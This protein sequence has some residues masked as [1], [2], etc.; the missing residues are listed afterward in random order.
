LR[1][2]RGV[3]STFP[4]LSLT[5]C[6]AS[7]RAREQEN[8]MVDRVLRPDMSL[9][10]AAQDKKFTAV[11]GTSIDK[12]LVAKSFYSGGERTTKSFWDLKGFFSKEF[13]TRK[14]SRAEAAANAKAN[15]EVAY[16]NTEFLTKKSSLIQTSSEEGKVAQVREYPD[17][18]PFLAKGTRQKILSQEDKPMT[19]DE[20]RELLNKSK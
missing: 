12:N 5:I 10:N 4:L 14:F 3:R 20:I 19:I 1:H 7:A 6:A 9:A 13:E 8:K 17:N 18:R 2:G 15:A 11:G 16:A